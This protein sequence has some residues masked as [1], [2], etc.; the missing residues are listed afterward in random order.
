MKAAKKA[1]DAGKIV[2]KSVKNQKRPAQGTKSRT[3]EMH[4][5]FQSDMSEKKQKRTIGGGGGK[6]KSSF[7][8]KSRYNNLLKKKKNPVSLLHKLNCIH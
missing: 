5:L 3:D 1:V 4:E 2:R 8:S 7:K 6:K